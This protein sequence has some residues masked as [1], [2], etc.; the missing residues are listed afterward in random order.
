MS[1]F[2]LTRRFT[3]DFYDPDAGLD[4]ELRERACSFSLSSFRRLR[5][6][7]R[8]ICDES[9]GKELPGFMVVEAGGKTHLVFVRVTLEGEEETGTS[10]RP[11]ILID[12]ARIRDAQPHVVRVHFH[13]N[14]WGVNLEYYGHDE[15]VEE[16]QKEQWW[17]RKLLRG[18]TARDSLQ[19]T[20]GQ[21]SRLELLIK[22]E[23]PGMRQPAPIDPDLAKIFNEDP[24]APYDFHG[25]VEIK[26][27]VTP[28]P[29]TPIEYAF[30]SVGSLLA[31]THLSDEFYIFTC[32]CGSPGCAG[33][34][35]G[36]DV[37]HEDGL[38]VWRMRG[39][40]PRRLLVFDHGQYRQEIITKV[41]TALAMAREI[42][43]KALFQSQADTKFVKEA[44]YRA[45]K[46]PA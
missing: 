46:H 1:K 13:S 21:T 2:K 41:R 29:R 19:L 33:I 38:V 31:S 26:L 32:D 5:L 45:E 16:L 6:T 44:L 39:N 4:P 25:S 36:V 18:R 23:V 3:G 15:F 24:G 28:D 35:A 14:E 12:Q 11:G 17:R 7:P 34:R 40:K 8:H 30:I 37:V 42:G 22:Q 10:P 9:T 27:R 20:G 43:P